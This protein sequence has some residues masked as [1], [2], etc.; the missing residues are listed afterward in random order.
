MNF[1]FLNISNL[2]GQNFL[3]FFIRFLFD[4][5]IIYLIAGKIY[6]KI[7][8]NSNIL[9]ALIML[10]ILVFFVCYLLQ[11][12]QLSIGFAF[13][14][15]AVFSILRYRASTI[16]IKEMT[17]VFISITLAIINSLTNI[18]TGYGLML[19]T[20]VTIVIF[21][22]IFEKKFIKNESS[23]TIQYDR[24][25]F[26]KPIYHAEFI[27]DLKEKT[28]LPIHRIEIGKIDFTKNTVQ[29]KIFY[30]DGPVTTDEDFNSGE[31]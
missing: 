7:R 3:E 12:V 14:I 21:A 10:N 16:P 8:R 11:S 31:G 24:I 1:D 23:K 2:D 19:F 9:F 4:F 22:F 5:V 20:N 6:Y 27:V 17:Y 30:Y 25:D 13:G 28:G 15:F 29:V 26:I 18:N